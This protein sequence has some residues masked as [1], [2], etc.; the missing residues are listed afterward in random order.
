MQHIV[1]AT[2]LFAERIFSATSRIKNLND[3]L[4]GPQPEASIPDNM[5]KADTPPLMYQISNGLDNERYLLEGLFHE[6]NRLEEALQ[7]I[8][9]QIGG[10]TAAKGPSQANRIPGSLF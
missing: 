5:T 7:M 1:Q 9:A 2:D 4:I 10:E 8:P 3:R 6:I